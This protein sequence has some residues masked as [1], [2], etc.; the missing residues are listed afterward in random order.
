MNYEFIVVPFRLSN[1]PVVFMFLMNGVFKEYLGNFV[2]VSLDDICIFS[3]TKEEHEQH[4]R[5]VLQ[6]LKEHK[7]YSKLSKCIFYQKKIH[8]MGHIISTDEIIFDPEKINTI[9]GWLVPR[10]VTKVKSFMGLSDY[11]QIFIKGFS[12][13]AIPIIYLQKK[14]MK[15][16]WTYDCEEKFQQPKDISTS[17]PILNIAYLDEYF[18]VCIGA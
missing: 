12:K 17:A 2:I 15:F 13:I 14:I 9:R 8:Y 1:S 18:L 4:L 10:N 16:E 5:M 6:V 3:N 7:L 11:Y